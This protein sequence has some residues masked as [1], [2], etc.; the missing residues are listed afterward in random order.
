MSKSEPG[1]AE[2]TTIS[3]RTHCRRVWH[4]HWKPQR[5]VC[6]DGP[7]WP[8]MVI[9]DTTAPVSGFDPHSDGGLTPWIRQC[10]RCGGRHS[11]DVTITEA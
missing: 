7:E 9:D 3:P 10:G 5:I 11:A 8:V 4:V 1:Y 6:C 2:I